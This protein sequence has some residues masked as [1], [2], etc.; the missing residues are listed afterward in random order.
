MIYTLHSIFQGCNSIIE[1][2]ED[3]KR[4]KIVRGGRGEDNLRERERG[5]EVEI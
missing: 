3:S 1:G 5:V 2:E 4:M